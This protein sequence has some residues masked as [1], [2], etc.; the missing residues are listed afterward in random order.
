MGGG[1][2][3][4][5]KPILCEKIYFAAHGLAKCNKHPAAI[6]DALVIIE[7][8]GA[9]KLVKS[10]KV[11]KLAKDPEYKILGGR[12]G[13]YDLRQSRCSQGEERYCRP[14]GR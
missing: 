8:L 6:K 1:S 3:Q 12:R 9:Q 5:E 4:E 2:C 10:E 11:V 7:G 14:L 13:V